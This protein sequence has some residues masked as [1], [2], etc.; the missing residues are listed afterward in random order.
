MVVLCDMS[1]SDIGFYIVECLFITKMMTRQELVYQFIPSLIQSFRGDKFLFGDF[2]RWR[3]ILANEKITAFDFDWSE[4]KYEVVF[5]SPTKE[6]IL[7]TFPEMR[8]IG[9][10]KYGAVLFDFDKHRISYI[11]LKKGENNQFKLSTL[12]KEGFNDLRAVKD[13]SKDNFY[14]Q[15][16]KRY[17]DYSLWERLVNLFIGR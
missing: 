11:V 16:R 5:P 9:D 12:T 2:E 10:A 14:K 17:I 4:L 1:I 3:E 13:M 6:M 15:L 7:Y 8:K